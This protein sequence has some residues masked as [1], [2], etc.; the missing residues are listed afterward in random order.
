MPKEHRKRGRRED[1]KR[2]REEDEE[3]AGQPEHTKR[4]RSQEAGEDDVQFILGRENGAAYGQ[5]EGDNSFQHE[6]PGEMQF[7]GM[8]D[9]QE[10]EY[11]KQADSTLDLNQ[12][13]DAEEK[14]LFLNNLWKE[15]RGKE[16]KIANSQ[17]CSRLMERLVAA[18]TSQQLKILWKKFCTHFLNL[19]QHR[20]A[21]H[22]CEALFQKAAPVVSLELAASASDDKEI[23][24]DGEEL[25]SMEDLFLGCVSE[26]EG[27]L[28][29]LITDQFASHPLRVLLVV[30]FGTSLEDSSTTSLLQSKKKEHNI[31]TPLNVAAQGTAVHGDRPVPASFH[32]AVDNVISGITSK[33][34]T[35][36]LRSM[37]THPIANPVLQL[38][39]ALSLTRSSKQNAMKDPNSIFRLLLPDDPPEEGTDSAAFINHLLY[40]PV[41]S[42]LLEVIVTHAPGKTFK[43]LCRS[44]FKDRLGS[45]ARNDTA[46]FVATKI[47]QR[48]GQADLQDVLTLLCKEVSLLVQ[49]S[50][51]GVIRTLIERCRIRELDETPIADAVRASYGDNAAERLSQMLNLTDQWIVATDSTMSAER[52]K[53]LNTTDPSLLDGSLLAQSM[54][55]APGPLRDLIN[56]SILAMEMSAIIAIAEDRTASRVLQAALTAPDQDTKFKRQFLPSFYPHLTTMAAH[57]VASH[58]VDALWEASTTLRFVR[59]QVA[60]E[61]LKDEA[62]LRAS[63]PGRAV[64]RNWNMDVYKTR[65]RE[66]FNLS[67]SGVVGQALA[68]RKKTGIELARER[69]ALKV[70][71]QGKGG[72]QK[73]GG[74]GANAVKV[75]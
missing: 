7:Y 75:T 14:T 33:L 18:S 53:Q 70:Q 44:L 48:L 41:G 74:S 10:Q 23:G 34:D 12:F 51:T 72:K 61:L 52:K 62:S 67:E 37:A 38:V 73:W 68:E 35:T 17:S 65:R 50:R 15:V 4:Q 16:L 45:I 49:R 66:W 60:A 46:A 71:K 29:Y 20:F 19:F 57:A 9:E 28:G 26:L 6:Q 5:Q 64:W 40:D 1:K 43:T 58:V 30:L 39:L 2:K 22:C 27:N 54:L 24:L 47:L 32:T 25:P 13:A 55:A 21:S 3:E 8:L 36:A 11:F 42:H 56:E 59:E 63:L 31:S 69:H